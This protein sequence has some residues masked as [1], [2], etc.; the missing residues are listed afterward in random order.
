MVLEPKIFFSKPPR[1]PILRI[2]LLSSLL[3]EK[4]PLYCSEACL[5]TTSC[6]SLQPLLERNVASTRVLPSSS[7]LLE[8]QRHLQH[9]HHPSVGKSIQASCNK[10]R[11]LENPKEL[12]ES[13]SRILE[14]LNSCYHGR[15]QGLELP[16]GESMVRKYSVFGQGRFT[17]EQD[18]S[19]C[20]AGTRDE[21]W[22][23]T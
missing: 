23:G 6:S 3:T 22:T 9:T 16:I 19:I 4:Q 7:R 14:S 17:V 8:L 10:P 2:Y 20:L 15:Q 13:R 18:L 11:R 5:L 1:R 21:K 12:E